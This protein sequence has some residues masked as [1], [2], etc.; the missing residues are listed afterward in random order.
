MI[1]CLRIFFGVGETRIIINL[2]TII[3]FQPISFCFC[4]SLDHQ[5]RPVR[6]PGCETR[7]LVRR[8][9]RLKLEKQKTGAAVSFTGVGFMVGYCDDVLTFGMWKELLCICVPQNQGA[10]SIIEY[11]WV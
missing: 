1:S 10:R 9:P 2:D 5:F 8:S 4:S 6:F 3:C 11:N 7:A